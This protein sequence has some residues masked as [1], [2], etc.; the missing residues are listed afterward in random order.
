LHAAVFIQTVL[1]FCWNATV[2]GKSRRE[3]GG[4]EGEED[5]FYCSTE[6]IIFFLS[7]H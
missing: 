2:E 6:P 1:F 7:S 3:C 5:F 4:N